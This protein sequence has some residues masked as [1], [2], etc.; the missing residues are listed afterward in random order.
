M[1]I[2]SRMI[3]IWEGRLI[4]LKLNSLLIILINFILFF[5]WNSENTCW[6][7]LSS[8]AL[9]WNCCLNKFRHI[10]CVCTNDILTTKI[11]W[12]KQGGERVEMIKKTF[13]DNFQIWHKVSSPE[14]SSC[15]VLNRLCLNTK[16]SFS[17]ALS[18]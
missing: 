11:A 1:P 18:N 5:C 10:L 7:T 2:K 6:Q 12:Y 8:S 17:L 15:L 14:T 13:Q 9:A 16:I 4:N 3:W